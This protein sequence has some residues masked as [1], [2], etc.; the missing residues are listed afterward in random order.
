M[1]SP[2]VISGNITAN[3]FQFLFA[4]NILLGPSCHKSIINENNWFK[5]IR[6]NFVLGYFDN[7]WSDVLQLDQ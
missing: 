1:I 4:P 3:M 6:Q 2:E 5:F 7:E